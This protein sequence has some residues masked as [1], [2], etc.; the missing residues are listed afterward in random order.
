MPEEE[1]EEEGGGGGGGGKIKKKRRKKNILSVRFYV[2]LSNLYLYHL[3]SSG[4]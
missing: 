2:H 3:Q 4:D 1:E